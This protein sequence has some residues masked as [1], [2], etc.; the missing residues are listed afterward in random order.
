MSCHRYCQRGYW[1][2]LI[3]YLWLLTLLSCTSGSSQTDRL[4]QSGYY[5]YALN[6]AFRSNDNW[7]TYI[8]DF[9]PDAHCKTYEPWFANP[10][11]IVF[12]NSTERVD[13]YVSPNDPI[14]DPRPNYL[15]AVTSVEWSQLGFFEYMTVEHDNTYR[16]RITDLNGMDVVFSSSFTE[17]R[18]L[19][20]FIDSM[21]MIKPPNWIYHNPWEAACEN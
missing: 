16:A 17:L 5:Y 12:T 1:F 21:V 2:C 13:V 19:I 15:T 3:Q 14:W 7:A 4:L 9:S 6:E 18:E 8:Y 10:V 11:Q 20:D